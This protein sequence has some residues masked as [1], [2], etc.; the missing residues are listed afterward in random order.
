V[1]QVTIYINNDLEKN[2]K[3]IAASMNLS[4]SK[5]ISG[6]L[7]QKISPIWNA[8]LKEIPGSWNDFVSLEEIR[9]DIASDTKREEI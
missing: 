7:E 1:A 2:I 8:K 6:I 3:D 4:M 5:F 9:N